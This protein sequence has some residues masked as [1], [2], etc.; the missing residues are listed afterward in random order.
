MKPPHEPDVCGLGG[1]DYP[2]Y[3]DACKIE[4]AEADAKLAKEQEAI[5]QQNRNK[6]TEKQWIRF[7]NKVAGRQ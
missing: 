4:A 3:C 5:A 1:G 7:K 2:H 6:A